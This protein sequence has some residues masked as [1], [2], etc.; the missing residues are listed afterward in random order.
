M[1]FLLLYTKYPMPFLP[2]CTKHPLLYL[3]LFT[4][5]LMPF[6]PSCDCVQSIN[7]FIF[8]FLQNIM[9]H[10][11]SVQNIPCHFCHSVQSIS[12]YICYPLKTSQGVSTT[13][14]KTIPCLLATLYKTSVPFLTC[15]V[16]CSTLVKSVNARQTFHAI[17]VCLD[18]PFSATMYKTSHAISAALDKIY[19]VISVSLE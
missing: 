10:F 2:L 7:C 6:L 19:N 9:C 13:L 4:K 3:L 12:C 17:S 15:L 5:Q 8:Y 1:T 16:I 14:D 11:C 18:Y